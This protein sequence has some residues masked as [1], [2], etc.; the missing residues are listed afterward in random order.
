MPA[1]DFADARFYGALR[2]AFKI[3]PSDQF[4]TPVDQ[5]FIVSRQR[6]PA[7]D[8]AFFGES[9]PYPPS[10][11]GRGDVLSAKIHAGKNGR[12][13]P[14]RGSSA[15]NDDADDAGRFR[16]YF[17]YDAFRPGPLLAHEHRSHDG[18]PT[19]S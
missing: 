3:R 13:R 12:P 10:H 6:D 7:V 5:G 11:H 8:A 15:E 1:D 16:V 9:D 14:F 18:L 17:L 19:S 4:K 2:G